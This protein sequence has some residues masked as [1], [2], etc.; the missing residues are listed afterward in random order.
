MTADPA[1]LAHNAGERL[2]AGLGMPPVVVEL[3]W[4]VKALHP[5]GRPHW[6]AKHKATKAARRDAFYATRA[7]T[8]IKPNW[9]GARLSVTFNPP[10]RRRRDKDG[11]IASFKA[12]QDGIADAIGVDDFYFVTTHEIGTPIKGG[13]VRV[14]ILP[15]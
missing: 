14:E 12:L 8:T 5:N 6:A 13:S 9:K 15:I 4:P 2:F 1:F 10:D 7:V 11:M 3:A